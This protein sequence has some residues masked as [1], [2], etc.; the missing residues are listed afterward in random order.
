MELIPVNSLID[1][2]H[3]MSL[4]KEGDGCFGTIV[5]DRHSW[6]CGSFAQFEASQVELLL[7]GGCLLKERWKLMLTRPKRFSFDW[8]PRQRATLVVHPAHPQWTAQKTIAF[9]ITSFFLFHGYPG[10]ACMCIK[11]VQTDNFPWS[12]KSERKNNK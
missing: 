3:D 7:G 12:E 6:L 11:L 2:F 10:A 4:L 1:Y 5:T 9:T 8:R